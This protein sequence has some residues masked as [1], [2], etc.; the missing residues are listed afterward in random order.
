MGDLVIPISQVHSALLPNIII[1]NIIGNKFS[2]FHVHTSV[3]SFITQ[4]VSEFKITSQI[5]VGHLSLETSKR[6]CTLGM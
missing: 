6:L 4:G 1:Y 2:S 3:H 5:Y